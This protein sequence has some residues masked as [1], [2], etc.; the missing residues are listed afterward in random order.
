MAR[1]LRD[2][3]STEIA[4]LHGAVVNSGDAPLCAAIMDLVEHRPTEFADRPTDLMAAL[5]EQLANRRTTS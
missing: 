4:V 1:D 3:R 5:D 2:G